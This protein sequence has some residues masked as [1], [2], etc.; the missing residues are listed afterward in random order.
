MNASLPTLFAM[1]DTV[2]RGPRMALN[3]AT[4]RY[5]CLWLDQRGLLWPFYQRWRD[6]FATD[7]TGELAFRATLGESPAEANEAWTLSPSR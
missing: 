7:P 6:G 1:D 3:Y 5:L 4:A 2:F